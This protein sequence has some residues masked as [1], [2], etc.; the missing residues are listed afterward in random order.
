MSGRRNG[1]ALR[2]LLALGTV[3]ACVVTIPGLSGLRINTTNSL[4]RGAYL[5]TDDLAAPLVEFC[6][7]GVFSALSAARGYRPPGLCPDG[8][9]PL[10]KPVIAR[11]GDTVVI[12]EAGICVNGRLLPNTSPRRVDSI[13]RPLTAWPRGTYVVD[14][15]DVW[16]AST[17]HPSSFDSRYFGPISIHRIWHRLRPLWVV[18][19]ST[20]EQ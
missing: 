4:P 17:Y 6:P 10:L 9:A 19:S 3:T 16:V 20:I 11:S 2:V 7:E 14:P 12:S 15:T 18:G 8:A 5:I 13:G 1:K